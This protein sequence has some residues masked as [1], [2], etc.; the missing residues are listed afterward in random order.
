[1]TT[2]DTATHPNCHCYTRRPSKT[3]LKIASIRSYISGLTRVVVHVDLTFHTGAK[4][5]D[6]KRSKE[7][8]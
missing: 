2:T 1:M 6:E 7:F 3:S 5:K 8:S 4:N